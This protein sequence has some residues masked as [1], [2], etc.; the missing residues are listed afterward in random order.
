ML[1]C[2]FPVSGD[3]T[4]TVLPPIGLK[5][6]GRIGILKLCKRHGLVPDFHGKH[7]ADSSLIQYN[8]KHS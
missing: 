5:V 2:Q 8:Q 7:F 3:F 4:K 1:L 6:A